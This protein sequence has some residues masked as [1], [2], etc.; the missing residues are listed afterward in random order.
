MK[1]KTPTLT[2][3]FPVPVTTPDYQRSYK[4]QDFFVASSPQV[5]K[6][7]PGGQIFFY[8]QHNCITRPWKKATVERPYKKFQ[9]Y[10]WR[11]IFQLGSTMARDFVHVLTFGLSLTLL[12]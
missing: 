11:K 7:W 2:H 4:Q 8:D 9:C 6:L 5:V 10:I 3:S 12:L 1:N